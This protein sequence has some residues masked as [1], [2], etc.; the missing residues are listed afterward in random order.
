MSAT[1]FQ[2]FFLLVG[3]VII[4][5][6]AGDFAVRYMLRIAGLFGLTTLFSG[7]VI[8]A[9]STGIPELAVVFNALW[10]NATAISTGDI[11]GS[12][13]IDITLVLGVA[14]FFA[15]EITISKRDYPNIIMML[16]VVMMATFF[17]FAQRTLSWVSG[18]LLI[19]VYAVSLALMWRTKTVLHGDVEDLHEE[20]DKP[21]AKLTK[22]QR[23]NEKLTAFAGFFASM[24]VVMLSS[25]L[26]VIASIDLARLFALPLEVVGSTIV[27]L[28]TSLPEL[29]LSVNAV[30]KRKYGLALGN[31]L[32][33]VLEQGTLILGI[34][35][36]SSQRPIS[37]A[38]LRGAAFFMVA[39]FAIIGYAI[40]KRKKI[41]R[42]DGGI[43]VALFFLFIAHQLFITN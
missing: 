34:Q 24:L 39:G 40:V 8:M 29:S 28:G 14:A 5:W 20:Q 2:L 12:N 7:F 37:I 11:I 3:A 26:V 18:L 21:V 38:S 25:K 15:R 19:A 10:N 42:L 41:T 32:G 16:G 31:S 4:L 30:L 17:V 33:S 1:I 36:V 23:Y 9:I 43:L 13:V 27:A 6:K 35:C 22:E